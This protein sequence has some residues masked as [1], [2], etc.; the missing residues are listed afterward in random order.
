MMKGLTLHFFVSRGSVSG[1]EDEDC[2]DLLSVK[3]KMLRS[4]DDAAGCSVSRG[5]VSGL[6]LEEEAMQDGCIVR[7]MTGSFGVFLN[8]DTTILNAVFATIV[9]HGRG[10]MKKTQ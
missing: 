2:S 9:A 7:M 6:L 10:A 1:G 3:G 8:I 4:D 5:S